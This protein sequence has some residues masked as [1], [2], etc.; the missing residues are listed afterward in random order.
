MLAIRH[1]PRVAIQYT[2]TLAIRHKSRVAIQYTT[3]L[4]ISA[5][6]GRVHT[7]IFWSCAAAHAVRVMTQPRC[8]I[9][10]QLQP[11]PRVAIHA[12]NQCRLWQPTLA[13]S[14]A[15]GKPRWQLMPRVA[16]H[17]GNQCRVWQPT[18]AISAACGKHAGNSAACG[19][20]Y[21]PLML[22]EGA[23]ARQE[24]PEG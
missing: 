23:D 3:T 21:P 16:N 20:R 6:C 19:N 9:T 7:E 18:L 10:C 12:G 15:C 13:I 17:A 4:A 5:A 8:A 22:A 11:A 24:I 1:K 14:A 2:T